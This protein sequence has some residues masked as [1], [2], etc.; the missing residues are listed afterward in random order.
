MTR[1]ERRYAVLARALW[2][3]AATWPAVLRVNPRVH[4]AFCCQPAEL[5]RRIT[6]LFP[7]KSIEE[8]SHHQ[9]DRGESSFNVSQ[10]PRGL[11]QVAVGLR[12]AD[13]LDELQVARRARRRP[14]RRRRRYATRRSARQRPLDRTAP[15]RD[16]RLAMLRSLRFGERGERGERVNH[17]GCGR[18]ARPRPGLPHATSRLFCP[19]CRLLVRQYGTG[20]PDRCTA[21]FN[22]CAT[23]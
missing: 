22:C 18:P 4:F 19:L 6:L 14:P 3:P 17:T 21:G 10:R 16:S 5:Y 15:A 9:C 7:P 20:R 2:L 8:L 12:R 11:W 23:A 1:A 13:G